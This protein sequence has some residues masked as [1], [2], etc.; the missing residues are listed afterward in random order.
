MSSF[1][2]FCK[3]NVDP[4]QIYKIKMPK[5]SGDFEMLIRILFRNHL[6]CNAVKISIASSEQSITNM[7][8]RI[9]FS[10]DRSHLLADGSIIDVVLIDVVGVTPIKK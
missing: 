3:T 4:G 9:Y 6:T 8:N 5:L 2:F 7:K 1:Q 10:L